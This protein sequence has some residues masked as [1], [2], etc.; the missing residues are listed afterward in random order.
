MSFLLSLLLTAA[1]AAP[2]LP[3]EFPRVLIHNFN[4]QPP[5]SAE[6]I[7][8]LAKRDLIILSPIFRK[9]YADIAAIRRRN[10]SIIILHYAITFGVSYDQRNVLSNDEEVKYLA[11][12]GCYLVSAPVGKL[13]AP[14]KPEDN[15]LALAGGISSPFDAVYPPLLLCERELITV[16]KVEAGA[17]QVLRGRCATRATAH[18]A[19]ALLKRVS[20]PKW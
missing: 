3:A 11:D 14:I 17:V 13:Q 6:Q 12:P 1:T 18:P 8:S 15:R 7:E 2:A 5:M 9:D 4:T 16:V 20:Q 10:P 19:G